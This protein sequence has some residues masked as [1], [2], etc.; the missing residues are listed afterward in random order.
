MSSPTLQLLR[1]HVGIW[2]GDYTHI[3]P[4]DRSVQ[5]SFAFRIKVEC[6]DDGRVAYR[7]TSR[8]RFPDGRTSELVYTG[9]AENDRLLIDDGRIRGAI[10]Q[11]EPRTLYMR[12]SFTADPGN[13]VTEMI[14]LSPDGTHRARTWHWLRD[15]RLWR[16]TLV[17]EQRASRDTAD[18]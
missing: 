9:W 3:D 12:F 6:P 7:Q 15:G 13:V 11:I 14:Q 17:R 5:E 18:W 2:E 16:I 10:W 4:R 8:Y 1:E